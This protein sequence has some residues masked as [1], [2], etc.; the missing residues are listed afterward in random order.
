MCRFGSVYRRFLVSLSTYRFILL[1]MYLHVCASVFLSIYLSTYLPMYLSVWLS[2][3]LS[4]YLPPYLSICLSVC[5]SV[6]EPV[7]AVWYHTSI[8][9]SLPV[10]VDL[11]VCLMACRCP[12]RMSL[13][14]L[15]LKLISSCVALAPSSADSFQ[16]AR[17]YSAA[18]LSLFPSC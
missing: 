13:F 18:M 7:A 3:C 6:C 12:C 2:V 9:S 15:D 14:C 16:W 5:L 10:V 1:P 4:F 8:M 17:R 11:G